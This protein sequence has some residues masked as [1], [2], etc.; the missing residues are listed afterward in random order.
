MISLEEEFQMYL[1][2]RA[3]NRTAKSIQIIASIFAIVYILTKL[4]KSK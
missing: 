3:L 4:V 2:D 1:E